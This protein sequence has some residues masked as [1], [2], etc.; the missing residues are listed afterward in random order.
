MPARARPEGPGKRYPLSMRTTI[1][2]R[3]KLEQAAAASG[4]S[5]AQ[6]VEY[7]VEKALREPLDVKAIVKATID[8]YEKRENERAKQDMM[9]LQM[10]CGPVG[11]LDS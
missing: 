3:Q 2:V 9:Y 7:L 10:L 1:E 11:P 8:E 5:L 4:R 6:E